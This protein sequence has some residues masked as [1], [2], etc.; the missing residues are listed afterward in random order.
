MK[1]RTKLWKAYFESSLIELGY[2]CLDIV[3]EDRSQYYEKR[4]YYIGPTVARKIKELLQDG[5]NFYVEDYN[6][7]AA[8]V[9]YNIKIVGFKFTYTIRVDSEIISSYAELPYN[10]G[11]IFE[12]KFYYKE[13]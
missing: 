13:D 11:K 6:V 7:F 8:C 2:K 4:N 10:N 5:Y 1:E 9:K 12:C 3:E